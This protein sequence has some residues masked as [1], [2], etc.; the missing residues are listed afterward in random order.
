ML[1]EEV[2]LVSRGETDPFTKQDCLLLTLL[3]KSSM[4]TACLEALEFIDNS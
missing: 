1:D 3:N 4:R 2:S